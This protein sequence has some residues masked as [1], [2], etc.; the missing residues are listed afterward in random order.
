MASGSTGRANSGSKGFDFATDDILC[1]YDDYVNPD[2]N[3]NQSD[4]AIGSG[5]SKVNLFSLRIV[6]YPF[7]SLLAFSAMI[8]LNLVFG[9]FVFG[10][11]ITVLVFSLVRTAIRA[12]PASYHI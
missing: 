9:N 8:S 11:V 12:E 7:S 1:S 5:S 6:I 4:S 2:S 3:G 10:Y